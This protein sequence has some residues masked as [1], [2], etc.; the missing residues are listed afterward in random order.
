MPALVVLGAQWGD[1]GKGKA[2][3]LLG[4]SVDYVVRY[5]GG[6]NAGHTVVVGDQKYA[7]HLLP[8]GILSPECTPV[9]GGGVV[10]DPSVLLSELAGLND[11]GIDTSKLLISGNAHLITPY[12][13]SLDKVTERFLGKRKIGTTGRGIGPAYAD[14]INRVGIRV[15]DLFDES[16]LRQKVDAALDAK[17]QVLAKLY[18]RRAIAADQV[19]E[20]LLGYAPRLEPFVADTTLLLNDA[21]DEGKVVLFEGGQGTLLDV[22]H[23]TYPFVTSSN[24]TAGGA[25]TG[26]GVGPTKINRVIGILKA[27]TTRV[28]AGP[29]P[30]ELEDEDGEAL[31]R[32]GGE[33]GVT[34]GRDRRC[35]WFDAVIA[36][37]AT[38]VN[39]LTDFFLTK[40]DVLTGWETIPVCVAYEI[41]GRRVEELPYNQSDFHHAKP[42]YE[43]LPGWT[44]DITKAK[45][46]DDLPANAR[47][48]VQA[49]ED[50]SGAPISAIGVGPGRDETIQIRP[51]V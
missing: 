31:R 18:N 5:Q 20:E 8:S 30:T 15:Q 13:T 12:H 39:G 28:G 23:G 21:I 43:Y 19:V 17:N 32:I 36:R 6:N 51:F 40:L 50:M 7:L 3:D 22:D 38:R 41:D 48:Y 49:L 10:V 47:A 35:G 24:P 45:S 44:E 34:T 29:F 1:E 46:L 9:I 37:Y 33:F 2:T 14:K 27:Y 42:I 4:G 16:I 11:R 25:C 26:A